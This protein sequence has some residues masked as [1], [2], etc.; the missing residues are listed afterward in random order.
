MKKTISLILIA[1]TTSSQSSTHYCEASGCTRKGT[2]IYSGIGSKTEY[3][4]EIHYNK[5]IDM[6]SE[7]EEDVGKGSYS[8]HT[9][10]E[11]SREGTYSI[12]GISGKTEYY[13][14]THYNELK[15][16]MEI[17]E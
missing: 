10:E 14:S 7:M 2:K 8:Q 3:Y 4:C 5:L 16:F 11:C 9:C 1:C 15:E 13:C 12:I 6:M 17:F